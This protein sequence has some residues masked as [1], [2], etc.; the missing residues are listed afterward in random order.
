MDARKRAGV[1]GCLCARLLGSEDDSRQ[2]PCFVV[3]DIV[4]LNGEC[5]ISQQWNV[6]RQLIESI[7]HSKKGWMQIAEISY[8]RTVDDLIQTLDKAIADKYAFLFC[9][10]RLAR[11]ATLALAIADRACVP[12]VLPRAS[13][14]K[15]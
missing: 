5:V 6:R 1:G 15:A 12:V 3:F 2:R 4:Y 11:D 14:R 8:G 10:R 7:L 9:A 13:G